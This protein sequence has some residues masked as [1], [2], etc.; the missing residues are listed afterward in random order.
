MQMLQCDNKHLT[1]SM[2]ELSCL[3]NQR[4]SL[5]QLPSP[6]SPSSFCNISSSSPSFLPFFPHLYFSL[7][8]LRYFSFLLSSHFLSPSFTCSSRPVN[9]SPSLSLTPSL[10]SLSCFHSHTLSLFPS[11]GF[12]RAKFCEEPLAGA[13]W[14]QGNDRRRPLFTS[15]A[16]TVSSA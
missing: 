6:L 12:N 4:R 11:I 8:P 10:I 7:H 5:L 15:V 1:W 14:G 13:P 9:L 3:F 16:P 2:T